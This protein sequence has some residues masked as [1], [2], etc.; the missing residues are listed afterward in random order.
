LTMSQRD[1]DG[2]ANLVNCVFLLPVQINGH[3]T[4]FLAL[5]VPCCRSYENDHKR[6]FAADVFPSESYD[7]ARRGHRYVEIG[8][9]PQNTKHT[10]GGQQFHMVSPESERCLACSSS[11][12]LVKKPVGGLSS[13]PLISCLSFLTA[14]TRNLL[15]GSESSG[16]VRETAV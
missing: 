2:F 4:L 12:T 5:N 14:E 10:A 3:G 11:W 6:T 13:L 1:A 9:L 15:L 8:P 16:T 7:A